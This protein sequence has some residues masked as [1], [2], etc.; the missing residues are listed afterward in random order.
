MISLST[1]FKT[2]VKKG[3]HE[4]IREAG[5]LFSHSTS[6]YKNC[7]ER[8]SQV[9]ERGRPL[10]IV[11]DL[12]LNNCEERASHVSQRGR[13]LVFEYDQLNNNCEERTLQVSQ[14]G[15]SLDFLVDLF[16]NYVKKGLHKLVK[17]EGPLISL[18][19]CF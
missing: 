13:P 19:T 3:L 10:D 4:I 5:L 17:E 14:R 9:F 2:A 18:S 11:V 16:I 7:E 8:T 1:I 6:L 12:F 15:R